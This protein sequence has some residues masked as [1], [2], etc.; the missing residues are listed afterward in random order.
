MLFTLTYFFRLVIITL[1]VIIALLMIKKK[2]YLYYA[3]LFLVFKAVD[4][5]LLRLPSIIDS[6]YFY[7]QGLQWNWLGKFLSIAW[8]LLFLWLGPL[9]ASDIGLTL[10]QR[11]GTV[12]PAVKITIIYVF[13]S[14]SIQLFLLGVSPKVTTETL[15]FQAT[16][17][18]LAEEPVFSGVL[19]TLI[20]FTLGGKIDRNKFNWTR[21]NV[22]AVIVVAFTFGIVHALF[23]QGG[24]QFNILLFLST[25]SGA[26]VTVWLRLY[27]GSLLFSI[28]AHNGGNFI[29]CL[30][31]LLLQ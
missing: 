30:I 3:F 21:A 11:S 5:L 13:I 19:L 15:L 28:L 6:I 1:I 29:V 27:T 8:V 22:I 20:I 7:S 16:M 31:F 14:V 10:K 18:G 12:F 25:V 9:S 24:L 23:Y 2:R 17:P 4:S 26:L